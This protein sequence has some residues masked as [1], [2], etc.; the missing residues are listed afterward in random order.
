MLKDDIFVNT[1]DRVVSAAVWFSVLLHM[2]HIYLYYAPAVG[3][4]MLRFYTFKNERCNPV[5]LNENAGLT[6]SSP[7]GMAGSFGVPS[8]FF[9]FS[10]WLLWSS[11]HQPYLL[12]LSFRY[13][14]QG[15]QRP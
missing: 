12:Y 9:A 2:K 5:F 11:Q 3:I 15:S 10:L 7:Q 1:R 6:V 14:I 8:P 4:Y 13:L